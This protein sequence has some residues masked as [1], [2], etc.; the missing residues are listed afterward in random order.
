MTPDRPLTV[1]QFTDNYGPGRSGILYAVQQIEGT[2][3]DGGHRVI[4]VAP[5]ATGPNPH[6]GRP[7]RTEVRLPSIRV[8]SVP[9]RLAS[10][11][12]ADAL[13]ARVAALEPDVIHVHGLGLVGLMGVALAR[14]T[15]IPLVVTWHTDWDAYTAHYSALA[16]MAAAAYRL[17]RVRAGGNALDIGQ[18]SRSSAA[19]RRAGRSLASAELLGASTAMLTAAD[20]VTTPSPKTA[21]RVTKWA[22]SCDVRSIPN[23][24]DRLPETGPSIARFRGTRFLYAGRIS[25]EKGIGLL[26]DA[27]KIVRSLAAD[28]ELMLVGDWKKIPAM[29]PKLLRARRHGVRLVGEVDRSRIG[30]YYASAD[31]FVFPSMTDTQA[32]VLH[33]AAHAGLPLIV[34]DPELRL[35]LEDGVNGEFA[36][37]DADALAGAMLR[38]IDLCKDPAARER[39]S[40]RGRELAGQYT[41]AGQNAA[42]VAVYA[43]VAGHPRHEPVSRTPG[44]LSR[45][46]TRFR[47]LTH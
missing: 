12:H 29:R 43:E 15:G 20:V 47:S 30:A 9:A 16:P 28:T 40:R 3:L 4:V 18:A 19:A 1:A 24:V 34:C 6:R 27:F 7:G 45:T 14:R 8:P 37:P 44:L 17:W 32:L 23:G 21:A 39:A 41:V 46:W 13:M 35:V 2:L 11:R 10:G 42:I 5:S 33:E 36:W 31:A 25:P 26:V 38:M 22:P